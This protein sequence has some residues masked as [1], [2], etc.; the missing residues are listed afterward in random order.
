MTNTQALARLLQRLALAC[1]RNP[2]NVRRRP[3]RG[4]QFP[5]VRRWN[6][7]PREQPNR[8]IPAGHS[9]SRDG[10]PRSFPEPGVRTDGLLDWFPLAAWAQ[11]PI[12]R[13]RRMLLPIQETQRCV[14]ERRRLL[15]G[16]AACCPYHANAST[17]VS[18]GRLQ[19]H[20]WAGGRYNFRCSYRASQPLP[21]KR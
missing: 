14:S 18:Y 7:R 3:D 12:A 10:G 17:L 8:E 16:C 11:M 2:H 5:G 19:T 6:S 13:S 15:A 21:Q 9:A 20:Y 4:P 1:S